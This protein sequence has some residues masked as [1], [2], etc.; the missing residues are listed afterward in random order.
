MLDVDLK[1]GDKNPDFWI[2]R[3]T[4]ILMSLAQ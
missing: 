1:A 3:G 2:L 4:A